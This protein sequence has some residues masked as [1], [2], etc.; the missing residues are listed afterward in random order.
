M[1]ERHDCRLCGEPVETA[2][3]LTP[4]PI[5]NLFPDTPLTG[6]CYPLEL[7]Q[8]IACGH[9][10]IGHVIDDNTLYGNA[11]KY[12]TPYALKPE[13]H[14][15]AAELRVEY[16]KARNVVEIG[17]NNGLFL[18][19]LHDEGFAPVI[20]IDPSGSAPLVWKIPFDMMAARIVLRRIGPVDLVVANNVFAHIDDLAEVFRA[21]DEILSPD[22]ALVFEVQY[23][24]AMADSGAFD[25]IYHEH[26]DYHTV[27]PLQTFLKRFGMVMTD[28]RVI[29]THGGS[30]RVTAK[31]V[32]AE[33]AAPEETVD[34]GAFQQK[35][36]ASKEVLLDGL[37][38]RVA[39]F[40]A[41]AKAITMIHHFGLQNR[42]AYCVDDTPQKQGK[43]IA[44][45]TIPV[46]SRDVMMVDKPR[47]M[48]LMSWNYE[49]L[50]RNSLP[51]VD[52][53][54]PF[55]HRLNQ[56]A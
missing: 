26:R 51:N 50:V 52:F 27:R 13:L 17:A 54:V 39:A 16:P 24:A 53:I 9:V 3:T 32:G 34:W 47:Q 6:E 25:M 40:G 55:S 15:R 35:I 42:I 18:H 29:G 41:P 20:G 7:K 1:Y 2:L 43:Y 4:T 12:A 8:C 5:A 45:T 23:F 31:R 22:G 19:A 48:L 14:K 38:R 28:W 37:P 49:H 56:A 36:Q 21:V 10:Q 46:V 11:Y 33:K 44:G 30:L